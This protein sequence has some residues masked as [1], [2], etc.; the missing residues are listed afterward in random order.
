MRQIDFENITGFDWDEG[1]EFKNWVKHKVSVAECE[2]VFFNEPF[3]TY[4]DEKH[5]L[6]E[7][8]YFVLGQTDQK[9]HLFIV[10]TIRKTLIRVISARDMNKNE[11]KIYEKLKKD[12]T[13]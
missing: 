6:K 3:F 4:V 13:I 7:D 9:R 11:R 8:R 10:F 12:T 2:E 5:S 1:N